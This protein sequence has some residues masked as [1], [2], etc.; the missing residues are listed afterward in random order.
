MLAKMTLI[1]FEKWLNAENDSIFKNITLP[2]GLDKQVL[3]DTILLKNAEFEVFYSDPYY[4]K[5]VTELFF[6]K[7]YH[8]FEKWVEGQAVTWNPIENYDRYEDWTDN[9]TNKK[10]GEMTGESSA[11]DTTEV[12]GSG[13]TKQNVTTYD[14]GTYKPDG[15]TESSS[16]STSESTTGANTKTNSEENGE[17]EN[18]HT[19]RIHGN[20][21]ITQSSDMLAGWRE[22]WKWNIYEAIADMYKDEFS[23][24]VYV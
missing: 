7:H 10:T 22:V 24:G 8:T 15:Q 21:G 17:S 6:N 1:S 5:K 12:T 16:G 3:V 11:A 20:I 18:I 19:G 2:T 4:M 14:S 23:V 9:G 13:E